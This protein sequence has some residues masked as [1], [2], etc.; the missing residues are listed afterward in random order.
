MITQV[1]S[2]SLVGQTVRM[3]QH[4]LRFVVVILL[5]VWI[6]YSASGFRHPLTPI[7]HSDSYEGAVIRQ[8]LF[9]A[10]AFSSFALMFLTRNIGSTLTMNRSMLLLSIIVPASI[11]WSTETIL[12]VKRA[13]LF[14]FA[15]ITLYAV[16]HA[17]QRPVTLMLKII[18]CSASAIAVISLLIHFAFGQAYTVNP[19]RPGLAGIASHP[20]TLAAIMSIALICSLGIH[21]NTIRGT[22]ALRGAQALMSLSLILAQSIT[23]LM[24][25][26]IAIGIYSLL[27]CNSYKRGILQM[28]I[29]TGFITCSIVG[30]NNIK[31]TAFDVSGRD[32]SLSGR[33]EVWKIVL[34]EGLKKPVFGSGYG[35]FWTEGKGRQLVHT[36]NPRQS[37]NA[38]LDLW[39]DLGIV[40]LGAMLLAFP[41]TLYMRWSAVKGKPGTRQRRAMAA[42]YALSISYMLTYAMAQSYF[43]RFDTF[44]FMSLCWSIILIGNIDHNRIENEFNEA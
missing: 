1:Q 23:T 39:L 41:W 24:A 12:S 30:W 16:V 36:W 18:T 28:L 40:G 2:N 20:N 6:A 31:S 7:L 26:F 13:I 14:L 43:L 17:S 5:L 44:P 22:I 25:T 3:R 33:D 19:V 11:I 10:A 15:L 42:L 9:S 38:Y 4:P 34:V 8:A 21:T 32:E 27:V 35:A 29:I 37:H